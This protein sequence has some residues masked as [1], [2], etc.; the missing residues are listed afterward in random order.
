MNPEKIN[1]MGMSLDEWTHKSCVATIGVG[2]DWATV[3]SIDSSERRKGHGTE[4]LIEMKKY[5]ES[6]GKKFAS[7]IALN[8]G[9]RRIL[10]KLN[11]H[12][13]AD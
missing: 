4:L 3:Y 1:R 13:Y 10:K 9:M 8:D 7:S 11:I 2:E 5:Y 6:Q 12:E